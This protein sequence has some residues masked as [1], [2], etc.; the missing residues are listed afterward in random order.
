MIHADSKRIACYSLESYKMNLM[1]PS[2]GRDTLSLGNSMGRRAGSVSSPSVKQQL[3]CSSASAV[4][5][6]TVPATSNAFPLSCVAAVSRLI[7]TKNNCCGPGC[8]SWRK[9]WGVVT[10]SGTWSETRISEII[11]TAHEALIRWMH[12]TFSN[13]CWTHEFFNAMT[14]VGLESAC[15]VKNTDDTLE[16]GIELPE[17]FLQEECS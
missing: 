17:K 4:R 15:S 3:A 7:N 8:D 14:W 1:L 11:H 13:L 2:Y 10:E 9:R 6:H 12:G 16:V 5:C